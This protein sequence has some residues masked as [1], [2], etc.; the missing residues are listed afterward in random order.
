MSK[1]TDYQRLW[2]SGKKENTELHNRLVIVVNI[3]REAHEVLIGTKTDKE[4]VKEL[5]E[6]LS[7]V[8]GIKIK[9]VKD[10]KGKS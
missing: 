10:G 9:E 7:Q 2:R 6:G 3:I 8:L 1:P 4:K 5:T